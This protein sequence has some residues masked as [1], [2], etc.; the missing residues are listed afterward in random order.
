LIR[1][2]KFGFEGSLIDEVHADLFR[3]INYVVVSQDVA[4]CADNHSRAK[5][6]LKRFTRLLLQTA[7]AEEILKEWIVKERLLLRCTH[8]PG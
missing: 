3:S 7:P 5:P 1:A 2:D 8:A 6:A 4:I